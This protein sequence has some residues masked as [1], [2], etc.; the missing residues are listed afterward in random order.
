M[1]SS[2][3]PPEVLE[4]RA[5]EQ[6]RRLHNSVSELRSSVTEAVRE[7]LDVKRYLR[8]YMGPATTVAAILGLLAGYGTAGMFTRK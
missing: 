2:N 6:R 7:K 1:S 8:E 4:E 5:A 3:L